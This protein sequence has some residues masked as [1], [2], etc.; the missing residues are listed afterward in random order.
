MLTHGIPKLLRLF[1]G[2]EIIFADPF[3]FGMELT[4]LLAVF[5]EFICSI[6]VMI[7]L[8]TRLAVIPLLI[9]ML[10]AFLIIHA[11]D[12]FQRKELAALYFVIFVVLAITGAG[13][14]SLDYYWQ[15]KS[16]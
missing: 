7:G 4:L 13:K 15:K 5:A 10:T 3:G 12:P 8:G 2:E 9:T 14:Y 11:E 6:L 16:R 1:S